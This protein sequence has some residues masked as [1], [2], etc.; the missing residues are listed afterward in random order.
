LKNPH[1]FP[2]AKFALHAK[3]N[4]EAIISDPSAGPRFWDIGVY[5]DCNTNARSFTG[6]FGDRYV[7]DTGLRGMTFFTGSHYFTGKEIEVF[8]ITD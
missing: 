5:S 6:S 4:K 2:A 3:H 8:E 1:N 7:N